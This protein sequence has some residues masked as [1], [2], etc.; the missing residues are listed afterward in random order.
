MDIVI[1]VFNV[2]LSGLSLIPDTVWAASVGAGIAYFSVAASNKNHRKTFL[3][4][5]KHEASENEKERK[6]AIRKDVYLKLAAEIV[7]ASGYL[8]TLSQVDISTTNIQKELSGFQVAANQ[9]ALIADPAT[10]YLILELN[11]QFQ[12]LVID[13]IAQLLPISLL[14]KAQQ[15]QAN[16]YDKTQVEI[17][18]ILADRLRMSETNDPDVERFE[19]LGRSFDFQTEM[20]KKYSSERERLGDELIASS[21][22]YGRFLLERMKPIGIE[23][24]KVLVAIRAELGIESNIEKFSSLL[25]D[26]R[27]RIA[28][29]VDDAFAKL[30]KNTERK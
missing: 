19:Q 12:E 27:E 28:K 2:F 11:G 26:L 3:D 22:G 17:H 18:R 6:I 25:S 16:F 20:A 4:Q 21:V 24:V 14:I 8:G 23:Q 1:L 13:A 10:S 29:K 9:A 5:L 30:P 15:T 7:S